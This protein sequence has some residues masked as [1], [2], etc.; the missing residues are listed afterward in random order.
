MEDTAFPNP[1]HPLELAVCFDKYLDQGIVESV[2]DQEMIILVGPASS[3]KSTFAKSLNASSKYVIACQDDLKTKSKVISTVKKALN[4]G[5]SVIVDRKN[6]Y[7]ADRAEFI[8]IANEIESKSKTDETV[9]SMSVKSVPVRI[10]WFDMCRD[11]SEHLS[12]Y[13]EIITGKHIP[14]IVMNKYY[15][16]EK[17]LQV[18][19]EEEGAKV[20][21]LYFKV[22]KNE[23]SNLVVFTS[24]LV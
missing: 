20:I 10:I 17:G 13:R 3:G 9:K 16:K 14:A 8:A 4:A 7:I 11:L 15:S 22:D 6:E 24:Y 12:T 2:D 19:T 5:Q 21:K 23:V 1:V 18:P